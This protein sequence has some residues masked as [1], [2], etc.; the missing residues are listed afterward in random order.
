MK[1]SSNDT[2]ND[3]T[4]SRK[5]KSLGLL[6]ENFCKQTWENDIIGIDEAAKSLG[7]E[8]RR[9]YDIINILESLEIVERKCKNQYQWKG[10]SRLPE[11]L[12][13]IQSEA[14]EELTEEARHFGIL[15]ESDATP[16]LSEDHNKPEANSTSTKKSLGRLSR[17]FLQLFLVGNKVMSLTEASDRIMGKADDAP[18]C[19]PNDKKA[20]L[21]RGQKTKI[22]RLYDIANVLA[23]IGLVQKMGNQRKAR[24]TF[25][26]IY[27]WSAPKIRSLV[28][29]PP[30]S[31][32]NETKSILSN[33]NERG[34]GSGQSA[35]SPKQQPSKLFAP[36]LIKSS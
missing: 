19:D 23:S 26:W 13:E 22:R 32:M 16:K 6:C 5:A 15:K 7:V 21:T 18:S 24:P 31:P 11:V 9:I 3:E 10:F 4:Y 27:H 14:I 36:T 35:P 34:A 33:I 17:Q 2:M 25:S 30:N 1:V 12:S 28:T 20:A 29:S 8:R